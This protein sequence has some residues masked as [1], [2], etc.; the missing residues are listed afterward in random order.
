MYI[1][2]LILGTITF[3]LLYIPLVILLIIDLIKILQG[4]INGI[5]LE[6]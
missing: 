2:L 4:E 3:G 1:A 5:K 6:G